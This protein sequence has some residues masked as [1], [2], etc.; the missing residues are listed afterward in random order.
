MKNFLSDH[1]FD[2]DFQKDTDLLE[3]ERHWCDMDSKIDEYPPPFTSVPR[4][5]AAYCSIFGRSNG[6]IQWEGIRDHYENLVAL[7]RSRNWLASY[8]Q[9][10]ELGHYV[11]DIT[12]PPHATAN[13]DG[14][15]SSDS[16]NVGIHGRY[17]GTMVDMY[18]GTISTAPG[19]ATTIEDPV[20]LGFD[21]LA[22]GQELVSAIMDADSAA[23]DLTGSN[24]SEEYY[25]TLFNLVGADAQK[26]LDLAGQRLADLWYTAWV[27]AGNPSFS[28][29]SPSPTPTV[30]PT[31]SPNVT[32]TTTSTPLPNLDAAVNSNIVHNGD[33]SSAEIVVH[34]EFRVLL[35][36]YCVILCPGNLSVS[37]V[38]TNRI[39]RGIIPIA[40][41]IPWINSGFR[42]RLLDATV[43]GV[44]PG[45]Y[46]IVAAFVPSGLRADFTTAVCYDMEKVVVER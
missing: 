15:L 9:A 13:F 44:A 32:P 18:I 20:E 37:V 19:S 26:R 29:V 38:E 22:G 12:C 16:R 35:D 3:N 31:P 1:A 45:E 11:A 42:T 8:Q 34:R 27:E 23:Q 30:T 7:M 28:L 4:D 5:Y 25:Q 24:E 41:S 33:R 40:R 2:P 39:H 14:N 17:E 46:T 36:A 10:A 6:V 21:I 43:A